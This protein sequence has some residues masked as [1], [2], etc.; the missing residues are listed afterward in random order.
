MAKPSHSLPPSNFHAAA[1]VPAAAD[2]EA[3]RKKLTRGGAGGVGE[4]ASE[5]L[6]AEDA[7]ST[8]FLDRALGETDAAATAAAAA[9]QVATRLYGCTGR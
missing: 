3:Y 8:S 7:T 1:A 4:R 5:G 2:R 9:A 6:D